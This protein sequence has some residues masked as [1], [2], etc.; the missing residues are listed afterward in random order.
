MASEQ[1]LGAK[2]NPGVGERLKETHK[3][4]EPITVETFLIISLSF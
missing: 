1:D 4:Q 3:K 2:A